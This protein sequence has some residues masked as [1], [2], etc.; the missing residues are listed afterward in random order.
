MA[1]EIPPRI[2]AEAHR[3]GAG[4]R[5]SLPSSLLAETFVFRPP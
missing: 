3:S 4:P 1:F 5:I 2:A